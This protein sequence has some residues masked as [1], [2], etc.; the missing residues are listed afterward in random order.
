M[1][2]NIVLS[3]CQV[4]PFRLTRCYLVLHADVN[5][6]LVVLSLLGHAIQVCSGA[7]HFPLLFQLDQRLLVHF[8]PVQVVLP[9]QLWRDLVRRQVARRN[10]VHHVRALRHRRVVGDKFPTSILFVLRPHRVA[11]GPRGHAVRR[12]GLLRRLL[13]LRIRLRRLPISHPLRGERQ[14]GGHLHPDARG[15]NQ[16]P[17]HVHDFEMRRL[18]SPIVEAVT[19]PS[20]S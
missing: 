2:V 20:G 18:R 10:H 3:L 1:I 5:I 7:V 8:A 15:A 13:R 6:P 12:P 11:H 4:E 9:R 19:T 16:T 14:R 17:A